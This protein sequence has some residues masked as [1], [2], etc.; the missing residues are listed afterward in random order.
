MEERDKSPTPN[1]EGSGWGALG[2]LQDIEEGVDRGTAYLRTRLGDLLGR[3]IE[4]KVEAYMAD[5]IASPEEF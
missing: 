4:K 5:T 2:S 1:D 3:I